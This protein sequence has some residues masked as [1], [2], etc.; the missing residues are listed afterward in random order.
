[1]SGEPFQ[2]KTFNEAVGLGIAWDAFGFSA[3]ITAGSMD[4]PAD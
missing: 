1:M 4:A 2:S 3:E